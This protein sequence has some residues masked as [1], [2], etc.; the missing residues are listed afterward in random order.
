MTVEIWSD[1]VCPFCYIGK[2]RFEEALQQF[3]QKENVEIVWRSFQLDPDAAPAPGTSLNQYLAQRKGVSEEEARRMNEYVTTT[4]AEAGLEFQLEKAVIGNTFTAHRILHLAK[5]HNVQNEV[6]EALLKTYFTEGKNIND[7][8]VL[9]QVA[10]AAGISA[11]AVATV[12]QGEQFTQEVHEDQLR[13]QQIGV[14]G[15][16]FFVFNNKYAVS[17][18]QATAVFADVLNKVW[19]E[20]QPV[21]VLTADNAACAVDG[22]NC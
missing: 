4:A 16:P 6:K 5:E 3:N 11:E 19:E 10:T 12:L 7:N 8:K 1:V 18:A 14:R 22:S 9:E 20:E 13:A 2:R 17:G 21:T 15:V